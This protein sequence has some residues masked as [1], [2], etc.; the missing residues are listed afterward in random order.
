MQCFTG[1]QH[2]ASTTVHP[3][4]LRYTDLST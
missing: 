3:I 4:Y 1:P 2:P